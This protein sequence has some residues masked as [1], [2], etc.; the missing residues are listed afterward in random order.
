MVREFGDD[1]ACRPRSVIAAQVPERFREAGSDGDG[2]DIDDEAPVDPHA[3]HAADRI[4]QNRIDEVVR[5]VEAQRRPV[6]DRPGAAP[7][8]LSPRG[9]REFARTG[10]PKGERRRSAETGADVELAMNAARQ[11]RHPCRVGPALVDEGHCAPKPHA[12]RKPRPVAR[13]ISADLGSALADGI[14]HRSIARA[15]PNLERA[16]SR[17]SCK[18]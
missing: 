9:H 10:P 11:C 18:H 7:V 1:R 16:R 12:V 14:I 4:E 15:V 6:A 5:L 8:V 17:L 13:Q 2:V 3:Q